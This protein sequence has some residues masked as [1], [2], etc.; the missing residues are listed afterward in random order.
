M[1]GKNINVFIFIISSFLCKLRNRDTGEKV[2]L[3]TF[4]P[5]IPAGSDGEQRLVDPLERVLTPTKNSWTHLK[6]S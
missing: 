6:E 3:E 1:I 5:K 2:A 4:K